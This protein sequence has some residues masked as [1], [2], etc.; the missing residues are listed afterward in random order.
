MNVLHEVTAE[1]VTDLEFAVRVANLAGK[2]LLE[3]QS[4]ALALGVTP[5]QL[6]DMGDSHSQRLIGSLL[7]DERGED[8]VLSEE[9][10]DDHKRLSANRVWIIDP[11]DGTREYSEGRSDWAV[12]VA[13]WIGGS[14]AVGAVALPGIGETYHSGMER[15]KVVEAGKPLRMAISR[16]RPSPLSTAIAKNL[17]A[18]TL[19][20]GSAGYKIGAVIRGEVDAY[21][22]SG[23][24]YEWD[25]AA[26]VTVAIRQGLHASRIDGSPLEYNRPDPYLP[27]LL[28]CRKEL[29]PSILS[30]IARFRRQELH[31]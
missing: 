18:T 20:M 17:D 7:R 10:E 3:M 16:S 1:D 19:P 28:V 31:T 25:S 23:G 8:A 9:A 30:G 21:L 22:H 27:D 5:S 2:M 14:L 6:K 15:K 24:Q 11:L 29:A 13:L 26:P 4:R 12:H